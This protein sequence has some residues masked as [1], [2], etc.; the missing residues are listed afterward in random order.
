MFFARFPKWDECETNY[1]GSSER[2][3]S[4]TIPLEREE[5]GSRK[6]LRIAFVV[7]EKI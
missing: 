5:L 1:S 4:P 2:A 7:S 3:Y 6:S